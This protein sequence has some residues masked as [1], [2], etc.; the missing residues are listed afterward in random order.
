MHLGKTL[1]P[2]NAQRSPLLQSASPAHPAPARA[3]PAGSQVRAGPQFPELHSGPISHDAPA[4]ALPVGVAQTPPTQRMPMRHGAVALHG[5]P[6]LAPVIAG[7]QVPPSPL[8]LTPT[9]HAS[10]AGSEQVRAARSVCRVERR[11]F[12]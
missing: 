5:S 4:S 9:P 12:A 8:E 10:H 3:A 2:S 7:G 11:I 1:L 6:T